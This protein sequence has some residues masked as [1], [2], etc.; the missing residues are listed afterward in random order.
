MF[1]RSSV[2]V[3]AG[4]IAAAIAAGLPGLVQGEDSDYVAGEML[5]LFQHG[6][7]ELPPG[8][9]SALLSEVTINSPE[10]DSAMHDAGVSEIEKVVKGLTADDTIA[11]SRTGETVI[12]SDLSTL[13]RLELPIEANIPTLAEEWTEFTDIVYAEANYISYPAEPLFANDLYFRRE[14]GGLEL[15]WGLYNWDYPGNDVQAP[16]A[17]QYA[18]GSSDIRIKTGDGALPKPEG[19]TT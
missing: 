5:V 2:W 1:G 10:V 9:E 14:D 17:W 16:E 3:V 18:T 6:V 13:F 7:I 8:T 19:S 12:L 4:L 15:Q 11:T